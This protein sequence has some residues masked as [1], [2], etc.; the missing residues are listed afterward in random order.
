MRKARFGVSLVGLILILT[1]CGRV[2]PMSG[3]TE[4]PSASAVAS[5]IATATPLTISQ[6]P[7]HMGEVGLAYAPVTLQATGGNDPFLWR[8]SDGALPGGLNMSA[9]GV[10]AGTPSASGTFTFTLEVMDAGL[11]TANLGVSI[12]VAPR[13]TLYYVGEMAAKG[14]ISVCPSGSYRDC[15][16]NT[17]DNRYAPF[18][19]V[20]GGV[21]PYTYAVVS[22]TLPPG[23]RLNGLAL[24]GTFPF[25]FGDTYRFTV[26]VTDSLGGTATIVAEYYVWS[27]HNFPPPSP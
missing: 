19:A 27:H 7:F 18:A 23:T 17:P 13:L 9:D 1:A 2:P 24:E 5:P 4:S 12:N 15:W 20:Q 11:A 8:V 6:P 3:A 16:T 10:V 14:S 26:A 22:G 25:T 21:P